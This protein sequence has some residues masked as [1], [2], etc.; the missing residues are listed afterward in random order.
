MGNPDRNYRLE[1]AKDDLKAEIVKKEED[2][3]KLK[4]SLKFNKAYLKHIDD[5]FEPRKIEVNNFWYRSFYFL[6]NG[7]NEIVEVSRIT[8]N[9]PRFPE[10]RERRVSLIDGKEAI[11]KFIDDNFGPFVYKLEEVLPQISLKD[12]K[13]LVELMKKK[14]EDETNNIVDSLDNPYKEPLSTVDGKKF[15]LGMYPLYQH[16]VLYINSNGEIYSVEVLD[17]DD[18][19]YCIKSI[20]EYERIDFNPMTISVSEDYEAAWDLIKN[21]ILSYIDDL[22]NVLNYLNLEEQN[23]LIEIIKQA[24]AE[25]KP[26]SLSI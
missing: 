9:S 16:L 6:V 1:K 22:P 15:V 26:M 5:L 10:E 19:R 17:R 18:E 25:R 23:K 21:N 12:G 7:K 4:N 3:E 24:R 20:N 2:V 14:Y 8:I 11:W 13:K